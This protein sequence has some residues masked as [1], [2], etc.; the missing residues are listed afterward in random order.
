MDIRHPL[1]ES[2]QEVLDWAIRA[3]LPVHILLTKSDK[4]TPAAARK[5]LREVQ[6]A[7]NDLSSVSVQL[8]SAIDRTGCDEVRTLLDHWLCED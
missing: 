1:K 2:D 3:E 6:E 5:T 4:L 7:L 8:F